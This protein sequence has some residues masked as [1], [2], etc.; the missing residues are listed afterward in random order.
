MRP[1]TVDAF[2]FLIMLELYFK[3]KDFII[4]FSWDRVAF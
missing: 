3:I 2:F 1:K 4:D